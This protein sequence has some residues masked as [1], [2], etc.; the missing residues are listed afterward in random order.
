MRP[1]NDNVLVEL[2]AREEAKGLI[3]V[4]EAHRR[5]PSFGTV[6][7]AGPIASVGIGDRVCFSPFAT[8]DIERENGHHHVLLRDSEL[9]AVVKDG[10]LYPF[11]DRVALSI[12]KHE[13][14]VGSIYLVDTHREPSYL[15]DV[16][17]IGPG[18]LM[19]NGSRLPMSV[20]VGDCVIIGE[21]AGTE[22][23]FEG[24]VLRIVTE[25]EI[26]GVCE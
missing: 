13:E 15:A 9:M 7:Q 18:R 24:E 3:Y 5:R 17:A 2:D 25:E 22:V 16:I 11:G 8:K 26:V 23:E 19:D 21:W 12:R 10:K 14:K 20:S 6:V 1:I 4:P